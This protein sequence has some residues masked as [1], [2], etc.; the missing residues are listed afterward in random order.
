MAA[1]GTSTEPRVPTA[2][3]PSC[4][5][6]T[7]FWKPLG[8]NR[9][10]TCHPSRDR[11]PSGE[12]VCFSEPAH[13]TTETVNKT[14]VMADKSLSPRVCHHRAPTRCQPLS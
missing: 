13:P 14:F 6:V 10:G 3:A 11:L 7:A 5:A 12:T 1:L 2:G 9:D 8:F 4:S